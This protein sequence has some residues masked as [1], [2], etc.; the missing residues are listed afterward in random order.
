MATETT[1]TRTKICTLDLG[2]S[3]VQYLSKR[4]DV[5]DGSLG[6]NVEVAGLNSRGLRL[7]STM[8]VPNNLQEYEIFIEDMFHDGAITYNSN[9]HTRTYNTGTSDFYIV[10]YAP[11]TIANLYCI[12]SHYF[13]DE[14]SKSRRRPAIK[15]AFQARFHEVEYLTKDFSKCDTCSS[16]TYSNYGHLRCSLDMAVEGKEVRLAE[17]KLSKLLFEGLLN[18]VHYYQ[19]FKYIKRWKD[20]GF[21]NDEGFMPLLMNTN[22]DIVSYIYLSEEDITII[23]PQTE[24]KIELLEKVFDEIVFKIFSDYVPEVEE[25]VWIDNPT[26]FLP[27]YAELI[28][29]QSELRV[30]YD[31][32]MKLIKEQMDENRRKYGFLHTLLTATGDDLVK[33][34]I[35]YLRW[36]GFEKVI[37]K[38]LIRNE[39]DLLEEDIQVDLGEDGLLVIEVKGVGGTSTDAQCSQIHKIVH[40][41]EKE[42][43]AFDVHGL[44]IV[45]NELYKE[46]LKRTIPPFSP[47][48]IKDAEYDERGLVYTWQLYNLFFDVEAGVI[49]K[50]EARKILMGKGLIDF[51]PEL[52]E[53]GI[54]YNYYQ[55]NSV[56]CVELKEHAIK[57]GDEL[58]YRDDG[59]WNVVELKS[60]QQDGKDVTIASNGKFGLGLAKEIPRNLP[61][62]I[63]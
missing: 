20:N 5:Y 9:D 26:Y 37:D 50:E 43:N 55:Q 63:K 54:P 33:A 18:D 14:L 31:A 4:F 39:G 32:D 10:S 57:V 28:Q 53:L 12:G 23:L 36:L 27:G 22:G 35:Q 56:I 21:V 1:R 45:N 24:K 25:S 62:Y 52:K 61:L 60:I 29:K 40:R 48:Q 11:Q 17:N 3:L 8:N 41:R 47:M 16:N 15:I 44:Y 13:A 51:S 34:M 7:L 19:A 30:K 58:Y 59:K 38:D 2:K 49:S 46:P 6:D 42:R